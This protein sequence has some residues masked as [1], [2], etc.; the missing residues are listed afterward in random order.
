MFRVMSA[1][2]TVQND[3]NTHNDTRQPFSDKSVN[4]VELL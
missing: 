2:K 4:L 3:S 1:L